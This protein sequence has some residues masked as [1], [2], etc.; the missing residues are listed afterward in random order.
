MNYD[1]EVIGKKLLT[2]NFS[3]CTRTDGGMMIS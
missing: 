2:E 1:S 3:P